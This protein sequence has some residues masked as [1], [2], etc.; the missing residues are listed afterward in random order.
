[1]TV[2]DI[3]NL[4]DEVRLGQECE[5][6]KHACDAKEKCVNT[7][8]EDRFK[9]QYDKAMFILWLPI[10]DKAFNRDGYRNA[11]DTVWNF[12]LS[13]EENNAKD[14]TNDIEQLDSWLYF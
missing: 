8:F 14:E 5:N 12:I 10:G 6:I 4:I 2:N 13:I 1:M 9:A 7:D 3:L 11:S